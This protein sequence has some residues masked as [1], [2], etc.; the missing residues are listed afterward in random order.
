MVD[1]C[2]FANFIITEIFMFYIYIL[3]LESSKKPKSLFSSSS[4]SNYEKVIFDVFVRAVKSF[5]FGELR[6]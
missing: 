3:L 4:V 1:S 2:T 5:H 6:F